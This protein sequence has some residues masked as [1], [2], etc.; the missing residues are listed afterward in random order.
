MTPPGPYPLLDALARR[1]PSRLPVWLMRQAG[2]YLPEYRQTRQQASGFLDF[3]YSPALAAQATLQPLHRF[4]LDA[5]IIFSDIL[6]VPQAL[7]RKVWF[8]EGEGPKLA[9]LSD[10][11]DVDRLES[12]RLADDLA[13]VYEAIARVR[14][15]LKPPVAL[16][17]FAGAPWTLAAYMIE[18][19]GSRDW[20]V[21]RLFALRHPVA[22]ARLLDRLADAIADH[23]IGQVRAGA[24]VLQIFDSWAG[25]IPA[26]DFAAWCIAPTRRL[27]ARVHAAVPDVPII[28]FPRG[29]GIGYQTYANDTGVS[30]ISIDQGLAVHWAADTLQPQVTVQGNLDPMRLVAGG[31][32]LDRAV[33]HIT[34]ALAGG[35]F[36]FNL[37]HGVVPQTPPEHVAQVVDRVH[38]VSGFGPAP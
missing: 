38:A 10:P 17:G 24:Q 3:C 29:A 36:V 2:R 8:V 5:A 13:P 11:A 23:L 28:G 31:D 32:G 9:P 19:S 35:P 25:A 18:G 15:E 14:A 37:G 33:D 30:G 4:D 20:A 7:G 26:M 22:F 6:V 21:A 12:S 16:I 34:G 1:R 27:V